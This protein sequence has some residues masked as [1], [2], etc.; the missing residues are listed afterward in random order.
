MAAWHSIRQGDNSSTTKSQSDIGRLF[1]NH[2][3][4]LGKLPK[5]VKWNNKTVSI[6]PPI[7]PS[8]N[9]T[10]ENHYP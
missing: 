6:S 4:P 10:K 8:E 9:G 3:K 7:G 5:T 2:Q 1:V